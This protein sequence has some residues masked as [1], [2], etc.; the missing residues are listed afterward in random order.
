VLSVFAF[1]AAALL[2]GCSSGIEPTPTDIAVESDGLV[3]GTRTAISA[4]G[5]SVEVPAWYYT[6]GMNARLRSFPALAQLFGHERVSTCDEAA[7]YRAAY[8]QY[9]VEHPNFALEQPYEVRALPPLT[10]HIPSPEVMEEKISTGTISRFAPVVQIRTTY[11]NKVW[12]CTG[13]FIAKNW[14][15]TDAHCMNPGE[16]KTKIVADN[17]YRSW[18]VIFSDANGNVGKQLNLDYVLQLVHF[19]FAGTIGEG[20]S[21]A[22]P[23]GSDF[24]LLYIDGSYDKNLPRSAT[25]GSDFLRLSTAGAA[26]L[27][28][29]A[30]GWGG[31]A[32]NVSKSMPLTAYTQL[33]QD[34]KDITNLTATI[35]S[36]DPYLCHGDSGGPLVDKYFVNDAAGQ[37]TEVPAAVATYVGG[38]AK[39]KTSP[40]MDLTGGKVYW[41]RLDQNLRFIRRVMRDR[42]FNG[43]NFDC[44]YDLEV[45][46]TGHQVVSC[47]LTPCLADD[48]CGPKARCVNSGSE[49]WVTCSPTTCDGTPQKGTCGCIRGKCQPLFDSGAL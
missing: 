25:P 15:M 32:N 10:A 13:S 42:S 16:D 9:A 4:E 33:S 39:T 47:W 24:A 31:P 17:A 6:R 30:W 14:I 34:P 26:P 8:A 23:V 5:E 1:F 2:V 12:A 7:A 49:D 46:S 48:E 11:Y 19:D 27:S 41:G 21:I 3:C 38:G 22:D 28:A 45:G 40:C 44:R 37:V 43:P 20:G 36:T 18:T 35:P 29:R